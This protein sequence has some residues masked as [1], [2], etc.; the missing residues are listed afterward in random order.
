[1][2]LGNRLSRSTAAV[3][4][5]CAAAV[6]YFIGAAPGLYWLDSAEFVAAAWELGVAHPPGHPLAALFHRLVC[7]LPVGTIA[8]RVGLASALATIGAVILLFF[9]CNELIDALAAG[10]TDAGGSPGTSRSIRWIAC[11]FGAL[12]PAFSYALWFSAVRAEVYALNL[13]LLLAGIYLLLRGRRQEDGRYVLASAFCF[14]LAL[15]NHH[16][17]ALLAL[18]GALLLLP[19]AAWRMKLGRALLWAPVAVLA[20]LCLLAYLPLRAE[21]SPSVNWGAPSTAERLAWVVSAKA[22][23]RKSAQR[24]AQETFEHR[25]MGAFFALIGG[26][27]SD[28]AATLVGG[29]LFLLGAYGMVLLIRCGQG[30]V[31]LGFMVLLLGNLL[32]PMLVGFDPYNPDAHGYLAL[33]VAL[34][35]PGAGLVLFVSSDVLARERRGLQALFIL[36]ALALPTLRLALNGSRATLHRHWAAEETARELI[37]LPPGT[38]LISS[39]FQSIFGAWALR[40]TEDARPDLGLL[41]RGFAAQPGYL[42]NAA[43]RQ[44]ALRPLIASWRRERKLRV[45]TLEALRHQAGA[46]QGMEVEARADTAQRGARERRGI[47]QRP[48]AFEYDPGLSSALTKALL[49]RGLTLRLEPGRP[50]TPADLDRHRRRFARYLGL[51]PEELGL[52]TRRALVWRHYLLARFGCARKLPELAG[53]HLRQALRQAPMSRHLRDLARRCLGWNA[54]EWASAGR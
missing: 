44:P 34:L 8:F 5:A 24:A 20:A 37:A 22:F 40:T 38:L 16:L 46:P 1:M 14:G 48:I 29:I 53:Y 51:L 10:R 42:D 41:H 31:A 19:R 35:G 27:P 43:R 6:P 7:Y 3:A 36:V 54:D 9:I 17:L 32:G 39:Y 30:L 33:A 28:P 25:G 52:E 18:P 4:V 45:S 12:S 13:L 50:V 11:G 26:P 15:C 2:L 49:P 47:G 23:Q 21:Q